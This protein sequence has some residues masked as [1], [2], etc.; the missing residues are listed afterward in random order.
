MGFKRFDL[1]EFIF[2]QDV[3][4]IFGLYQI[5]HLKKYTPARKL[6]NFLQIK[7]YIPR[8]KRLILKNFRYTRKKRKRERE[9]EK[10]EKV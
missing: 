3:A 2:A 4:I 5:W 9:G 6:L 10:R 8:R 7:V 1:H